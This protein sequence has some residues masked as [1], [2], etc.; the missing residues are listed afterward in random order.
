LVR[1]IQA[2]IYRYGSRAS[3]LWGETACPQVI[4]LADEYLKEDKLR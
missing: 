4:G 3:D 1:Q 2:S